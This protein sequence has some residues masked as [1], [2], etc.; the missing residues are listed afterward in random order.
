MELVI[1]K[2]SKEDI[3]EIVQLYDDLNNYLANGT[4]YPGWRKGIYPAYEDAAAGVA[5]GTL[6]VAKTGGKVVGSMVLSHTQPPAYSSVKWG[7]DA[8]SA[9][10]F[11]IYTFAVHP[12]CLKKGVGISLLNF[13]ARHCKKQQAKS[14]RLDVYEKNQ[15]AI[16]LY[17]KCGFEYIDTV[18]LGLGEYGLKYFKLYEKLL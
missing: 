6:Y 8:D 18:D 14:I 11:V 9:H 7:V 2:G 3:G 5:E 13:A 12:D 16:K 17:Q 15:P 10:I 4:N 1:E